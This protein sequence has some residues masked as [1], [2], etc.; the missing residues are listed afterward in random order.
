MSLLVRSVDDDS[1]VPRVPVLP[2]RFLDRQNNT[3]TSTGLPNVRRE[4][5]N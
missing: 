2:D 1:S 4:G 3:V 5:E